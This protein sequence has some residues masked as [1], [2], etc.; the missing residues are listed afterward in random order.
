[1]RTVFQNVRCRPVIAGFLLPCA[2]SAA[3][4]APPSDASGLHLHLMWMCI[5][6]GVIVFALIFYSVVE[7]RRS[8]SVLK[9]PWH[10]TTTREMLWTAI[11]F[12]MLVALVTPATRALI[13]AHDA[14]KDPMTVEVS[15]APLALRFPAL[16]AEGAPLT[17]GLEQLARSAE[18]RPEIVLPSHRRIHMR[19]AAGPVSWSIP[20]AGFRYESAGGAAAD[21]WLYLPKSGV[22]EASCS[23]ACAPAA[24]GPL[25]LRVR[26]VPQG[27]Y[28]E[29]LQQAVRDG[30]PAP[31]APRAQ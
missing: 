10:A 3:S 19:F 23:G 16:A 7:F 5:A 27:V 26:A 18:G 2:A 28:E 9:A 13:A 22:Y 12:V 14:Q 4:P 8:H 25:Q 17:L 31:V 24:G 15:A 29:W 20:D 11:P 1:M 21:S 30:G 6:V